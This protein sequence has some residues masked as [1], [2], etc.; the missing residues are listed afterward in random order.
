VAEVSYT[1]SLDV[2]SNDPSTPTHIALTGT[3]A[4]AIPA[5]T[6]N[7][8][9][10]SF[11]NVT[12]DGSSTKIVTVTNT[13]TAPLTITV[14]GITIT[15]PGSEYAIAAGQTTCVPGTPI[16]INAS[17]NVGVTLTP[18]SE[19]AFNGTLNI[20]SDAP[21]SP[22][23]VAMSGTGVVSAA[24]IDV[25]PASL[26]FGTAQVGSNIDY[27]VT[28]TNTGT[29]DLILSAIT[30]SGAAA[31]NFTSP[32]A[33][34]TCA[35]GAPVHPNASCIITTVFHAV[36]IATYNATLTITSNA[37]N[38]PS[39]S[40]PLTGKGSDFDF[41]VQEGGSTSDT[42]TAGETA[43]FN[44][45]I[46]GTPGA[47]GIA[48]LGC[49]ENIPNAAC[50]VQPAM[51]VMNDT[52][53]SN[54]IVS[55]ATTPPTSAMTTPLAAPNSSPGAPMSLPAF[56]MWVAALAMVLAMMA[57]SKRRAR[58][59]MMAAMLFVVL[60]SSCVGNSPRASTIRSTPAGVYP[61]T[62]TATVNGV[63]KTQIVT[64]TVN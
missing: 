37:A 1:A 34:S 3:G 29:D 19:A 4:P 54:F 14:A 62:V 11:G 36:A 63:T 13:G 9:S 16:A 24:K 5:I 26:D 22:T 48:T 10:L 46:G 44:L 32:A 56:W 23:Q 39:A 50:G 60:W 38:M 64:V 27:P 18:G 25:S 41:G 30:V 57:A 20:L 17:C 49:Q 31:A 8:T 28:V 55:V 2:G 21:T 51:V 7:P 53:P 35:V 42:V 52:T 58:V 47:A 15:Q 33:G 59:V 12:V 6:P 40:G 43:V 61:V 45:S